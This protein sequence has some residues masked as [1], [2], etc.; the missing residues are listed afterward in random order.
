[1][2]QS[3]SAPPR[4]FHLTFAKCGSQWVRDV[5]TAPEIA[6]FSGC[7]H[8]PD[9]LQP[10]GNWPSPE[11]PTIFAPI[12]GVSRDQWKKKKAAQDKAV[13]VLRD[14]R[15]LIIS[16]VFS[17]IH[18]HVQSPVTTLLREPLL[19][20][21]MPHRIRIALQVWSNRQD[22][23]RSWASQK[24]SESEWITHYETLTSD[25]SEFFRI[26]QFFGWQVPQEIA[27]AVIH[28]LSFAVR[29][30]RQPGEE[31]EYS[32]YRKGVGGDW[33]NHFD[34]SL[35][36]LFEDR[37][38]K[39]LHALGYEKD[40]LWYESL[41]E[42]VEPEVKETQELAELQTLL[43][44]RVRL[45]EKSDELQRNLT[46][47]KTLLEQTYQQQQNWQTAQKQLQDRI[48]ELTGK[49]DALKNR[50][51]EIK[52]KKPAQSPVTNLPQKS[53]LR[54]LKGLR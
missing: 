37:C 12:Y 40:E 48:A 41:P 53:W 3:S 8:H 44:E 50:L 19:A 20:L 4:L 5:L 42:R 21:T 23:W 47:V 31:N 45:H 38:P 43:A 7:G 26:F 51:Q 54:W 32:H 16:W 22:T 25:P 2:S 13:L 35:G 30:G 33:K 1:M 15:D 29:S 14:P 49:N 27:D 46:H 39:L 24:S 18:S 36:K 10:G 34:R 11:T 52:D 6:M 28:R 9:R 17:C